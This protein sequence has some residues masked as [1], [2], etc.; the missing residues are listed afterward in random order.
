MSKT[1]KK[2]VNLC[3]YHKEIVVI[4]I[5]VVEEDHNT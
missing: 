2:K 3:T 5:V 4:I 1:P